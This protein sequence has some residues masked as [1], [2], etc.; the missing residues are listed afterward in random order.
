MTF[1]RNTT[2]PSRSY[3]ALVTSLPHMPHFTR[4]RHAPMTRLRLDQRLNALAP[5]DRDQ[6][7]R[8]EPLAAWNP[9]IALLRMQ[10][11][12]GFSAEAELSASGTL[13]DVLRG[14]FD[15]GILDYLHLRRDQRLILAALRLR[16]RGMPEAM[17]ARLDTAFAPPGIVMHLRMRWQESDFGLGRQHPWIT[18][19]AQ[20]LERRD[21]CG[22]QSLVMQVAWRRLGRLRDDSDPFGLRAV[23]AFVFAWQIACAW[24]GHD[25]TA[26]SARF[27]QLLDQALSS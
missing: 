5:E 17:L 9:E 16:R 12:H 18:E 11:D 4:L 25:A 20:L 14:S 1:S 19:A 27:H 7:A 10:P 15:P 8:A 26:A 2:M 3:Y 22:L 24:T 13:G 6:I 21:A 23:A